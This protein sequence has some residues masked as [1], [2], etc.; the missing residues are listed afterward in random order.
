[1]ARYSLHGG[2]N[3]FVQGANYGNRKEHIMDRQVKDAVVAKLRALG[4]TVYD[5][6]DEVGTT[7]AQNLNNIV[8]KTNSHNVDLVVS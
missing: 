5:D 3:S 7:Q 6:T 8:S 2:H 1:M 4:H